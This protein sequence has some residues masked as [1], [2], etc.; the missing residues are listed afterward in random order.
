ML[1]SIIV[2]VYNIEAYIERCLLSIVQQD[3]PSE[4]YEIILVNDGSTDGSLMKI[5]NTRKNYPDRNIK[6]YTKENGGLSSARNFGI[7][8]AS[9]EYIWFIDG[10]DWVSKDSLNLLSNELEQNGKVDILEFDLA[11]ALENK[12]GFKYIYDSDH[13]TVSEKN[14]TGRQFLQDHGYSLGVTV[15]IYKQEFLL[16]SGILFPLGKYSEDNIFSLKTLLLVEK[17][18]KINA[19]LYLYYQ[20]EGSLSHS[21]SDERLRK[22]YDDIYSNFFEMREVTLHEN[23]AIKIKIGEMISYFQLLLFIGLYKNKKFALAREYVIKMKKDG[24][25]PIGKLDSGKSLKFN[26][27]RKF[28]NLLYRF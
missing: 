6:I 28:I 18:R 2:P 8:K 9:A 22:Y 12:S 19:C 26:A 1:I 13:K 15:K 4:Q 17:Y 24:F 23:D 10:D 7:E 27:F 5:E 11:I 21:K 14:E 25:F 16:A 3:F 20:R